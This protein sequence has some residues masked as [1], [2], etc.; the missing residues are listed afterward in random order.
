[1]FRGL[2]VDDLVVGSLATA[3]AAAGA[4]ASVAIVEDDFVPAQSYI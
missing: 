1:M 3:I 4:G 2:D